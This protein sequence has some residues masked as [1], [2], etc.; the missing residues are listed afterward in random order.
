MHVAAKRGHTRFCSL[1]L[2]RDGKA[3]SVTRDG[4]LPLHCAARSGHLPIVKLFLG[5][6]GTPKFTRT[7]VNSKGDF[8][9]TLN[10]I[11]IV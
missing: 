1:L 3:D 9:S 10:L 8:P 7:K 4:L 6:E 5:H 11:V 2:E